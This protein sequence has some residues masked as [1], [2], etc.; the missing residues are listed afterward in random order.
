M[1]WQ[2]EHKPLKEIHCRL[3]S[4]NFVFL[5]YNESECID[6]KWAL[7][8]AVYAIMQ[9]ITHELAHLDRCFHLVQ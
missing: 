1:C 5:I 8:S 4:I 7:M 6:N 3:K 2:L 9:Q